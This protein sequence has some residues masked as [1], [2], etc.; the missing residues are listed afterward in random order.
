MFIS[1]WLGFYKKAGRSSQPAAPLHGLCISSCLHV[2]D[3]VLCEFLSLFLWWWTAVWKCKLSKS[4]P[5]QLAFWLCFVAAIEPLS[6]TLAMG[7]LW[8][9]AIKLR[10]VPL[11]PWSL[12]DSYHA[13]LLDFCQRPFLHLMRWSCVFSLL[14][15]YMVD[16]I[17]SFIYS[18]IL[19]SLGWR[20]DHG[21]CTG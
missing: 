5:P 4:F 1:I 13:R 8:T 20:L 3:R 16:Y 12:Q 9:A 10:D 2:A 18:T 14:F 15:V 6:K 21:D 7:L 11:Y 19:A 17:Y